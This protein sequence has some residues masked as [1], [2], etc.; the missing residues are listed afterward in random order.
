LTGLNEPEALRAASSIGGRF[1][2]GV[3]IAQRISSTAD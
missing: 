3:D 2:V 1:P